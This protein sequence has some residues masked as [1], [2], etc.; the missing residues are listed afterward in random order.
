MP[1]FIGGLQ[2]IYSPSY[3]GLLVRMDFNCHAI[4]VIH[5]LVNHLGI[6]CPE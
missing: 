1:T 6:M 2:E 4:F 3:V 5:I